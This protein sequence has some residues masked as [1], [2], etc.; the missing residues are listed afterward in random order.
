VLNSNDLTFV[1]S[2]ASYRPAGDDDAGSSAP[3]PAHDPSAMRAFVDKHGLGVRAVGVSV[4]D[5]R[6]AYEASVANGGRGVLPPT[7]LGGGAVIAEVSLYGDVV[8]RYVSG[9]DDETKKTFLPKYAD[10][11]PPST[12]AP[13]TYGLRRL[14]HAV[15]NVHDLLETV[16]Y[17][18]AFTGMHQF[19]EFTAE[20]VGTVDSG[21]NSMVLANNNEFV[22]LPVNEPTFGTKRKSQIQTYLEQNDGPGLQHL[23]LKTDDVFATVRAMRAHG[24]GRGGFEFQAPASAEYYQNMKARVGEDALSPEQFAQ[25]QELGL[26][27]DRDD[28]GVLVQIFTKPLGDRPTVFIEIIQRVGCA[29]EPKPETDG[30]LPEREQAAGCGGFGKGNFSEL[31]KSIEKYE[32]TLEV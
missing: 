18:T 2:A 21:L 32:R 23:A 16:D 8:L 17:I 12:A 22:L 11:R 15:G 14:D 9:V 7:D 31:F 30:A 6:Q 1:F 29:R 13:L 28:Q 27:V 24:G 26:L 20:D 19:A 3:F 4:D 25:V 5:A 10:A